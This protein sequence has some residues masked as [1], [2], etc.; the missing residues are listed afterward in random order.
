MTPWPSYSCSTSLA[1]RRSI[2]SR[3]GTVKRGGSIRCA[4]FCLR[5]PPGCEADVYHGICR[6]RYHFSSEPSLIPLRHSHATNR[7]RS[8]SRP[9]VSPRRCTHHSSFARHPRRSTCKRSSKSCSQKPSTS[10]ASSPRLKESA[11]LY[12]STWTCECPVPLPRPAS[13]RGLYDTRP[14]R[15]CPYSGA[16]PCRAW[17]YMEPSG[18][19]YLSFILPTSHP[20]YISH[21]LLSP[22]LHYLSSFRSIVAAAA[23]HAPPHPS[24]AFI[25]P[26]T[27]QPAPLSQ[28]QSIF[29][30][31]YLPGL[32]S[33]RRYILGGPR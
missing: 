10:N 23:Y 2:R 5:D 27:S 12:C 32:F 8:Q 13:A 17:V 3:S 31:V 24:V 29:Q 22:L 19:S 6:Q 16:A 15:A 7:R 11:S 33:L 18:L 1:S 30:T 21:R 14:R 25:H 4:L 9:S 20:L 28:Q 26:H